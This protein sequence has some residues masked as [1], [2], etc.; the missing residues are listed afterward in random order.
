MGKGSGWLERAKRFLLPRFGAEGR[1]DPVA[2]R[3]ALL[4]L[5]IGV[6]WCLLEHGILGDDWI[7][8]DVLFFVVTSFLFYWLILQY[9]GAMR[10]SETALKESE[11][12]LFRIVETDA[13]GIVVTDLDRKV[14]F[15]NSAASRILGVSRTDL[16]GSILSASDW[17]M[18][19]P[20]GNP[21]GDRESP[22]GTVLRTGMPVYDVQ[23]GIARPDGREVFLSVNAAP[24]RDAEGGIVGA[25]ASFADITERKRAEEI[26]RRKLSLAVEQSPVAVV[27]TDDRGRVEYVNG[28][29]VSM[30]GYGSEEVV[31]TE[32]L[33]PVHDDPELCDPVCP[34]LEEAVREGRPWSGQFRNRRKSG[35]EYWEAASLTPVRDH[36]GKVANFFWLR[37]DITE[38]RRADEALQESR[39]KYQNLVETIHDWAWEVDEQGR[40][41]Y[42]S[43]K[44]RELL[45]YEPEEVLGKTPFD[46]MPRFEAERIERRFRELVQERRPIVALEN[47]NRRKDGRYAVLETSGVPFFDPEGNFRGYR[48]IDRDIS[49]R[50]RTEEALRESEERFRQIFEQNEEPVIIFQSGTSRIVDLNPAARALYGHSKEEMREKGPSLFTLPEEHDAFCRAVSG[51]SLKEVLTIERTTHRRKDGTRIAVSVRGKAMFLNHRTVSYLTFRNI[52]ERVRLEEEAKLAQAR[53]IHANRM[54]NLGTLV[55]GVAHEVNNPNNLI[56]FNTPMLS[57]AWND[58]LPILDRYRQETGDFSLAGLPYSEMRRAVPEL[59]QGI[60]DGS[61][62]IKR[63]VADL[64]DFA[65]Q[66]LSRAEEPVD[67]NAVARQAVGILGHEIIRCTNDF[68]ADYGEGLPPVLG[69]SQQLEQVVVNLLSNA[70]QALPDKKRAIRLSTRFVPESGAV[71]IRLRDEGTGMSREVLDRVTEPFFSTKQESGGLGLGLALSQSIVREHGG[72]LDFDSEPGKGTTA[73]VLLPAAKTALAAA[74]GSDP[75]GPSGS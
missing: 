11:D 73:R 50:K 27:I 62:R 3:I 60:A 47:I 32:M 65:R 54:A 2:F 42:V 45:G 26:D 6:T 43:P 74:A 12:R 72:H 16:A 46:L 69:A 20:E 71:E 58:I 70:L 52:S 49:E 10:R 24:L 41:S 33:C 75:T 53:L 17:K 15:S 7:V 40:Y 18:T 23:A 59:L 25:V 56:M 9:S 14:F 63:I 68:R 19:N 1:K 8:T 22:L 13:S 4:Y 37:E 35:E 34:G 67:V 31:G 38:H 51:M 44:V 64:K 55:S 5:S 29:F 36:E 39:Q 21:V 30:T 66:D 28:S 61:A 48:G 57:A